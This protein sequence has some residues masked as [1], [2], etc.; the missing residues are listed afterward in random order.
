MKMANKKVG[1]KAE[2]AGPSLM[3][4]APN[5]GRRVVGEPEATRSKMNITR[6]IRKGWTALPVT[7]VSKVNG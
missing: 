5:A 1:V 6:D 4:S 2:S 3:D 7:E